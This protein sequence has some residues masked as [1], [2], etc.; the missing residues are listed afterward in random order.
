MCGRGQVGRL[1][2]AGGQNAGWQRDVQ[3]IIVPGTGEVVDKVREMVRAQLVLY[4][5]F[6]LVDR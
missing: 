2:V 5:V 6:F 3:V 4:G 1:A